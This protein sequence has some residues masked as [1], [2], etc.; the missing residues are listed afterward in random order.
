MKEL[1]TL[2]SRTGVEEVGQGLTTEIEV[3]KVRPHHL[4]NSVMIKPC[5]VPRTQLASEIVVQAIGEN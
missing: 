3:P 5:Q 2:I 4:R 1:V